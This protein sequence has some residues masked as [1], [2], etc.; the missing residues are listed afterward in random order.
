[1]LK[2]RVAVSSLYQTKSSPGSVNSKQFR[3]LQRK[4]GCNLE[5]N[6]PVEHGHSVLLT[7]KS[8]VFW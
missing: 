6:D 1:M 2:L 7:V 3:E 8:S 4:T 5:T